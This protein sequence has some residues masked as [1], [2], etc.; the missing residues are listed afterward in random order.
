MRPR[1]LLP[2]QDV[3]L[4]Y[5]SCLFVFI[6]GLGCLFLVTFLALDILY[7]FTHMHANLRCIVHVHIGYTN[8]DAI[9][10]RLTPLLTLCT[11]PVVD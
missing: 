8:V 4:L 2:F 7:R 1:I 10:R 9:F 11:A 5:P 6:P 3:R